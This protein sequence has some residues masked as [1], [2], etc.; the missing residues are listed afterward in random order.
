M[1]YLSKIV[2]LLAERTCNA[3]ERK[4]MFNI[5]FLYLSHHL[6]QPMIDLYSHL[7]LEINFRDE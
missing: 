4:K 6:P 3:S 2:I 1:A 5:N 7:I